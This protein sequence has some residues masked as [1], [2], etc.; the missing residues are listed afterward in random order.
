MSSTLRKYYNPLNI[1]ELLICRYFVLGFTLKQR[2]ILLN[3]L[4]NLLPLL[5]A[6]V[7]FLINF[8]P[9]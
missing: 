8:D 5:E 2:N 6:V 3:F 7:L 4:R 9:E 1:L